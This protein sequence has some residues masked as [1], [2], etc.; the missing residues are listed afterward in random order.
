MIET[1]VILAAGE[2]S[3]LRESTGTDIPK[4]LYPINGDP[5]IKRIMFSL[6][7][8]RIK[9]FIIVLGWERHH[10][11]KKIIQYRIPGTEIQF[12]DNDQW[13]THG[14]GISLLKAEKLVKDE[15][16]FVCC[17]GDHL[18]E[19]EIIHR[20]TSSYEVGF[21]WEAQIAIDL[22]KGHNHK[23]G[24]RVRLNPSDSPH[25]PRVDS[26]GRRLVSYSAI[27]AGIFVF[28][29][30]FFRSIERRIDLTGDCD[31][32][33]AVFSYALSVG[34]RGIDVFPWRW[35]NINDAKAVR[36]AEEDSRLCP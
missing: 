15:Q 2:G 19:P 26:I 18:F 28:P 8:C 23:E 27:D 33:E 24:T 30:L 9:R 21:P 4:P 1:A 32:C 35:L 6:F 3:R 11:A 14:T 22:E 31:L 12:V 17:M 13:K 10:L 25:C 20:L 5:L 7:I 16:A 34:V 36:L 29:S